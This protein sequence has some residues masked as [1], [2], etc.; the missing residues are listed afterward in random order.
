MRS[1]HFTTMKYIILQRHIPILLLLLLLKKRFHIPRTHINLS[2][3]FLDIFFQLF[4]LLLRNLIIRILKRIKKPILLVKIF[5]S[6]FLNTFL[7]SSQQTLLQN[8]RIHF[9]F[10]WFKNLCMSMVFFMLYHFKMKCFVVTFIL[11]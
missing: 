11:I 2:Q 10:I 9:R 8:F 3:I 5:C 7:I 1:M 4:F 6:F